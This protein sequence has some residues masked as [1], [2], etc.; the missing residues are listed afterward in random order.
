MPDSPLSDNKKAE[1][2]TYRQTLRNLIQTI[3]S[4]SAYVD[5]ENTN[6]RDDITWSWPTKPS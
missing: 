4:D 2:T 6:P 5:E 3:K 1:W